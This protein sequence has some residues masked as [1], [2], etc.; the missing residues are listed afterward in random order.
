MTD[1]I[2]GHFHKAFEYVLIPEDNAE[3]IKVL[4]F[5]GKEADFQQSMKTHFGQV[6]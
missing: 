6:R 1:S 5:E 2:T 4:T 3:G